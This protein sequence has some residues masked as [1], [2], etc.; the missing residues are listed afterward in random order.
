VNVT[1]RVALEEL[2]ARDPLAI[3][4]GQA[5]ALE[6]DTTPLGRLVI[7]ERD[8]GLEKTAY[9]LLGD[10]VTVARRIRERA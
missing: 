8:G 4:D 3:L 2:D 5:N 10:L 6:L 9:A 7:T 1:A